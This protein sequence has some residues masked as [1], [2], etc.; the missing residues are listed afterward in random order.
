MYKAI[1][2]AIIIFIVAWGTIKMTPPPHDKGKILDFQFTK[3]LRGVA[4]LLVML[5]HIAGSYGT[6]IFTPLGGTGVAI[7]YV[8]LDMVSMSHIK[9]MD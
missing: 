1:F 8:C 5:S 3:C 4:I 6:N 2:V 9:K 7:F